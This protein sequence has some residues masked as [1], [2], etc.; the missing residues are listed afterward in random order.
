MSLIAPPSPRIRKP[1]KS[2]DGATPATPIPLSPDA[3]ASPATIVPCSA[4]DCSGSGYAS[5]S[6]SITSTSCTMF[7][8][9]W[10]LSTPVSM[11]AMRMPS[12]RV[13]S[14]AGTAWMSAV[15]SAPEFCAVFCR[16]H[17]SGK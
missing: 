14:Q 15:G 11:I 1:I 3:A 9:G 8:S 17:C 16:C 2:A 7:R 10:V 4:P 13:I 5:P 12:P 6:S